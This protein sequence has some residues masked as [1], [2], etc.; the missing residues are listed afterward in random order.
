MLD[1]YRTHQ[2]ALNLKKCTFLV[3]YGNLLGHVVCRQVLMVDP[4]KIA[5][6]LFGI[7]AKCETVACYPRTYGVLQ[8]VHQKLC[9][10]HCADGNAVENGCH[11]LLER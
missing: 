8:E 7:T 1:T 9:P 2:I 5:V 11:I 4:V 6:I 3:P 10:D